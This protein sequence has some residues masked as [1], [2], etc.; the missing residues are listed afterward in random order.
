MPAPQKR[1]KGDCDALSQHMR[2]IGRIPLL[3]A[4][5]E[6]SLARLVQ[7]GCRATDV[8]QEMKLRAGGVAP[9]LECQATLKT[10]PLPTLKSEPPL[11]R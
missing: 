10:E 2:A 1:P 11:A 4:E 3:S 8:A 9:S 5:E 6:I 7:S